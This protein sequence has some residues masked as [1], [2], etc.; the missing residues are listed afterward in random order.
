[1]ECINREAREIELLPY[2]MDREDTFFLSKS[3]KPLMKTLGRMKEGPL[4]KG[5]MTYF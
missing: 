2:N 3:C 4:L 1:M 5:K